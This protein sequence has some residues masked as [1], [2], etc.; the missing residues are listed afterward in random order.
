VAQHD[1]G[2]GLPEEWCA[3]TP[4]NRAKCERSSDGC[5]RC[6]P[7]QSR[8]VSAPQWPR[9]DRGMVLMAL[10]RAFF[11][12]QEARCYHQRMDRSSG[13]EAVSAE[14]LARRGNSSTRPTA[15]GVKEVRKWART[16][17][18]G[19]SVIDVGCGPGFPITVR[20]SGFRGR[21]STILCSCIPAQPA[22]YAHPLRSCSRVQI[23]WSNLR[24]CTGNW[25]DVPSQG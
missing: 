16:L 25:P 14:F 22:R 24:C 12:D 10:R 23:L 6:G 8:H 19:S 17:L 5:G 7:Q 2:R 11:Q 20:T 9:A 4:R 13:Y 3:G 1:V 18:R 15:I 21:C